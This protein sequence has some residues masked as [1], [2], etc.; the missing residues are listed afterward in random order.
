MSLSSRSERSL[1]SHE[2]FEV[3]R[4]THHPFIYDQDRETLRDLKLRL[5]DLRSKERTLGRQK[6]RE[7]RGK[8]DARGG[9]FPGT[10]EKPLQRKQI[11]ASALKRT[12]AELERRRRLEAKARHV[13]AAHKALAMRNANFEERPAATQTA[14]DGMKPLP[15]PRRRWKVPP[16]KIGSVSKAGKVSQARRDSRG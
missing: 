14:K 9:S 10:Y 1:L 11:F 13:E 4:A 16:A 5:R 15:N 8:G 3:V 12:N 6:R 7:S 2:E